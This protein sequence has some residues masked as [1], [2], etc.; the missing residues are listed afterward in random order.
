MICCCLREIIGTTDPEKWSSA[1]K[2]D[3]KRY[4]FGSHAAVEKY[5]IIW[6]IES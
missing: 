4:E 5:L 2:G 1:I 3:R 6:K